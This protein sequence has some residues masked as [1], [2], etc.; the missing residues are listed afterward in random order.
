M[1]KDE[2]GL[3][4]TQHALKFIT[5]RRFKDDPDAN[6]T[7]DLAKA[8]SSHQSIVVQNSLETLFS[9]ENLEQDSEGEEEDASFGDYGHQVV[10]PGEMAR[11]L[12]TQLSN[13]RKR[14]NPTRN[15][16]CPQE[17]QGPCSIQQLDEIPTFQQ[18]G[19]TAFE[20]SWC[21]KWRFLCGVFHIVPESTE[22]DGGT[23]FEC[24][25]LK[26]SDE[27]L[28]GLSCESYEQDFRPPNPKDNFAKDKGGA[29]SEMKKFFEWWSET[30]ETP[31]EDDYDIS[32][33]REHYWEYLAHTGTLVPE[34]FADHPIHTLTLNDL[35]K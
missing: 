35:G 19:A 13:K 32:I 9:N 3:E 25:E 15:Q 17:E 22:E 34:G 5:E 16:Q 24:H 7:A 28:V 18:M 2:P 33:Y 20:C 4:L 27:T 31:G 12:A 14:S 21:H 30:T 10:H 23:T 8:A 29:E 26:W 11:L 6:T 1:L